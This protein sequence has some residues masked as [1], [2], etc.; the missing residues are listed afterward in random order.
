MPDEMNREERRLYLDAL[1]DAILAGDKKSYYQLVNDRYKPDYRLMSGTNRTIAMHMQRRIMPDYYKVIAKYIPEN[2]VFINA[3]LP[4]WIVI[5]KT[6]GTKDL[7]ALYSW[8]ATGP[9]MV[10]THYGV[11]QDGM[12]WQFV[13]ERDGAGGN[14]C[15]EDGYASFLPDTRTSGI[16]L[17][18]CTIPIEHI[19]PATDNSTLLTKEQQVSSFHLIADICQRHNIPARAGD[20]S[21]G[22]IT[23]SQIAPQTRARCPGN[24]PFDA[25]WSFLKGVFADV[26]NPQGNPHQDEQMH[27]CWLAMHP[28]IPVGTGIYKAWSDAYR[29]GF[30]MGPVLTFENKDIDWAGNPIIVQYFAFAR[31]E[32][33]NG[34][35]RWFD[36]RG[37]INI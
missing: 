14:C 27:T 17:N 15:V 20:A 30:F 13:L 26:N 2:R 32:W 24:Y 7:P 21:G 22:I 4:K 19:D 6:G 23:H 28:G 34:Q 31:C 12:V 10:S 35:A 11:G 9:E 5:H 18:M 25:L 3:N 16:N 33:Q 37:E 1:K 36:A 29:K 8:F